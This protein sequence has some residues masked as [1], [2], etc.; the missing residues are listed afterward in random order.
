MYNGIDSNPEE[1]IGRIYN[2][3]REMAIFFVCYM[4]VI[5]FF[6]VNIFVGFVIVTFRRE[7][8]QD[9]KDCEL[10]KNQA[11]ISSDLWLY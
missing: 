4:V 3:R 1:S 6:M 9:H 11:R 7:G 10:D 5:A 2:R 8:E